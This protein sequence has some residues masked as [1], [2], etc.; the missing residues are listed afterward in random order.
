MQLPELILI[1]STNDNPTFPTLSACV[2]KHKGL[3]P[4]MYLFSD[5]LCRLHAKTGRIESSLR[6]L[7]SAR[8]ALYQKPFQYLKLEVAFTHYVLDNQDY[9][10]MLTTSQVFIKKLELEFL[11][12]IFYCK[13]VCLAGDQYRSQVPGVAKPYFLPVLCLHGA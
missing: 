11:Y 12:H 3:F 10:G 7:C 13:L 5:R 2:F 1:N 8:L 9:D 4:F 6:I